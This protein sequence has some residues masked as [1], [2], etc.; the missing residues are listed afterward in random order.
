LASARYLLPYVLISAFTYVFAKDGLTYAS[1]YVL[2]AITSLCTSVALFAVTRG[3]LVLNRDTVLFGFFYWLSNVSWLVGLDYIS[4]AQSA[5]L[6]YTMPLFAI[7]LSVYVLSE[8][9]SK[10]EAYGAALGFAGI[11]V[12]NL[13]LLGGSVTL[14]G[15]VLTLTDAVFWAVFSV[16]MRKL[17][18]QDPVQTLVTA[19][20]MTFLLF[21]IFSFADFRFRPTLHL[22]VDVGYVG[23]V[24]GTLNFVLWMALLRT[25]R[26]ARL[27]TL[28]FLAPVV[29]L[30]FDAAVTGVLPGYLTLAGVS[31]IFA[32][33]YVASILG[34]RVAE[35]KPLSANSPQQAG[36]GS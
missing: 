35:T 29:T 25:E 19:S 4:S 24:S 33:I 5:V 6:S 7:P 26:M 18:L 8:R 2:G 27:T 23:L 15:A 31:L 32:G 13:P 11:V 34:G 10:F 3:R 9:A 17:R 20:F 21:G 14:L 28:L 12:Y 36:H 16:Y 22:A 1:P 30:V